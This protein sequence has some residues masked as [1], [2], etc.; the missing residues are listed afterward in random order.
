MEPHDEMDFG[1]AVNAA[2][3]A[4]ASV[5]TM[6][7]AALAYAAH[8]VPVFPLD[9]ETKKPL[10]ARDKDASGNSIPGTGGFK[11]ATVDPATVNHWWRK[12]PKAMIGVAMGERV[13][14]WALDV[15][16]PGDHADGLSA[17]E[18][19]RSAPG[20]D[21]PD[22]RKHASPSGGLQFL[23]RMPRDKLIRCGRGELPDGID[24]KGEGGYIVVPPS[25]RRKGQYVVVEDAPI[26]GAPAWLVDMI[27]G[28]KPRAKKEPQTGAKTVDMRALKSA[29]KFIPNEN[30]AWD[31]WNKVGMALYAATDGKGFELF[32]EWSKKSSKYDA[33]ETSDRWNHYSTSPPTE[34]T[35]GTIFYRARQNGWRRAIFL[36]PRISEVA[37]AAE[38]AL[39]EAGAP[40]YQRGGKL[41]RPLVEEVDATNGRRTKVAQLKE[42]DAVHLRDF[43]DRTATWLRY[44]ERSMKW[45]LAK[46]PLD[47][48]MTILA[49]GV[50]E[51]KFCVVVGIISTPTMRPDGSLLVEPGYDPATRLLLVE[52]PDMPTIP[53]SPTLDDA[54]AALA[55]LLDLISEF[56][57]KDDVSRAVALSALITPVVRGAFPV[58]PMHAATAPAAGTGKSYLMD[59]VAA[60][61]TGQLMPVMSAG[62][63]E[64]EFEKRLGA[65]M[66]TGQPLISI[67]NVDG[68]LRGVALCQLIERPVVEIRILGKSERVRIESRATT[69]FCTGNNLAL[70]GDLCRRTIVAAL[71]AVV[72]RPELREFNDDP[73]EKVLK[74]R[75]AYI[76]AA[77]TICRAYIVAGRPGKAPRLASFEAW[78]DIVRS[79]LIWLGE[80]DVVDSMEAAR[81]ED[82]ELIALR[83]MLSA[84]AATIGVGQAY[85]RTLQSAIDQSGN[86]DAIELKEAIETVAGVGADVNSLARWAKS[87][88]GRVVEGMRLLNQPDPKGHSMWWVEHSDGK[89]RPPAPAQTDFTTNMT[90]DE[91]SEKAIKFFEC[92]EWF[93]KSQ[94]NTTLQDNGVI[95]V[96]MPKWLAAEKGLLGRKTFETGWWKP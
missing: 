52:P 71:D 42:L 26:V 73:V 78:S 51:R 41:F 4:H 88:K 55:L 46:P 72:E 3:A 39:L 93:P 56:P 17:F 35:A 5:G 89:N 18:A 36:S 29:M 8:G 32:D 84:W 83:G 91:E 92:K 48:A 12:Y 40:L 58:T 31:E 66:L 10:T 2:V 30:L 60:I 80:A 23:F 24:V 81:D 96:T 94:I 11:K 77:L 34:L 64:E 21:W 37:T 43:M 44:D 27:L 65:A 82:P 25:I 76:A 1:I 16:A 75:G 85:K 19:L 68:E 79:A 20:R 9:P 70:V 33:D 69:T 57:L 63:N 61:S 53:E 62:K 14:V 47:V 50:D 38:G 22:T 13:G 28:E 49:R 90:L 45:E 86:D 7:S 67:D 87:K 95:T 74:N 6:V 59:L 54:R 15:D